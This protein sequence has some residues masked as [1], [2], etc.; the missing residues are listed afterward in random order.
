MTWGIR[1]GASPYGWGG[2]LFEDGWPRAWAAEEWDEQDLTLLKAKKG[3][4]AW[5]AEWELLAVLVA[6]DV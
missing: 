6:V 2:I 3:D 5:Q 1:T 4:P